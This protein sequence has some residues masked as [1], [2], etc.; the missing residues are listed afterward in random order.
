MVEI[1]LSGSGEGPGV[2]G[3]GYST[4]GFL[5]SRNSGS[6]EISRP[7]A[8]VDIMHN[9]ARSTDRSDRAKNFSNSE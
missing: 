5:L 4:T 8:S 2:V 3:R 7:A 1:S 9:Y 6:S